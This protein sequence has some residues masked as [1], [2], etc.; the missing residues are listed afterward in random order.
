[1]RTSTS[2][3]QNEVDAYTQFATEK[4]VITDGDVGV[5]NANILCE[6]IINQDFDITPQKLSLSFSQVKSQLKFKRAANSKP[7]LLLSN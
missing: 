5:K 2:L 6:P 7:R 1:M 3:T 4:K